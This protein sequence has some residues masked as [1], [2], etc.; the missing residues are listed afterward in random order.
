MYTYWEHLS[1]NGQYDIDTEDL[2]VFLKFL[3]WLILTQN[4]LLVNH[5]LNWGKN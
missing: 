1:E 5:N 2:E 3:K 4:E